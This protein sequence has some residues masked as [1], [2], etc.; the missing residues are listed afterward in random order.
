VSLVTGKFSFGQLRR[1]FD[2]YAKLP[3]DMEDVIVEERNGGSLHDFSFS[4]PREDRV[5]AFLVA[6]F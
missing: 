6:P 3:F 2:Y 5:T 1:L 4:S